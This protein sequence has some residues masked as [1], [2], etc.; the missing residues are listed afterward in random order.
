MCVCVC[1]CVWVCVWIGVDVFDY[2]GGVY[3]KTKTS[4][5]I[6]AGNEFYT[7]VNPNWLWSGVMFGGD[8]LL[9][10]SFTFQNYEIKLCMR[11]RTKRF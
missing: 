3:G 1:V 9:L 6:Y 2:G 7:F 4:T 8:G 10:G 11:M 5:C